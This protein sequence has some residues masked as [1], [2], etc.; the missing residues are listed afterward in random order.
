M[1]NSRTANTPHSTPDAFL[2]ELRAL[3]A[4]AQKVLEGSTS[5]DDGEPE[6][7]LQERFEAAREQLNEAC[8]TA[9][10]KVVAGGKFADETIRTNP[11]QSIAVAAGIALV[12]G[13]AVGRRSK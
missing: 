8:A 5:E 12:I 4:E 9:K 1:K 10:K 3:V 13:Y 7:S 6:V 2:A 11:Y